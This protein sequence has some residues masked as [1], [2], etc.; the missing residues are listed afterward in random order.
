VAD[1][2]EFPRTCQ[3]CGTPIVAGN[4]GGKGIAQSMRAGWLRARRENKKARALWES[5]L[6]WF[7]LLSLEV[8]RKR[9]GF[10][11][12]RQLLFNVIHELAQHLVG[13]LTDDRLAEPPDLAQDAHV[14][15]HLGL[16]GA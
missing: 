9:R 3:G 16:F 5:G 2:F 1:L 13:L 11:A 4:L 7:Y 15:L 6:W 8:R 14:G 10:L 12:S